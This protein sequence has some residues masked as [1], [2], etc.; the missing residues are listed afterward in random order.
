MRLAPRAVG[1]LSGLGV[2]ATLACGSSAGPSPAAQVEDC[3]GQAE[4]LAGAPP[5]G[6]GSTYTEITLGGKLRDYRLF[7]PA[8]A[9]TTGPVSLVIEIPP[10]NAD[11]DLLESTIHFDREATTAGFLAATPNGCGTDWSYEPGP[12]NAAD[13]EFIR[14]MVGQIKSRFSIGRVFAISASGGSR[15]LYRLACDLADEVAA[16]ADVAGTMILKDPCQPSR[17]VSVLEIH[18]TRD[19]DSPWNGGGP[20]DSY[21]VE[22]VNQRWRS[23]DACVGSPIVAGVGITVTTTANRCAAGTVV[24]LEKVVGGQHTWFGTGDSDAVPGEPHASAD[25]WSFFSA[26]GAQPK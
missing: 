1:L 16:V 14:R 13:E 3:R 21:P 17:P 23:I 8:T 9:P 15:M 25:V 18:G 7:R 20:H 26:I 19:A 22:D 11:A 5:P 2:L 6:P 4:T 10:P 24:V 12:A